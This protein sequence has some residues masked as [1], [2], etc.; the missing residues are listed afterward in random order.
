VAV[1]RD[2]PARDYA[3]S[4]AAPFHCPQSL[5]RPWHDRADWVSCCPWPQTSATCR[6]RCASGPR[7]P[8]CYGLCPPAGLAFQAAAGRWSMR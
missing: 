8:E 1:G 5:R 3:G 7:S 6:V 4:F 2:G